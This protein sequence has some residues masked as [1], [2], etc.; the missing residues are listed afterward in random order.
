MDESSAYLSPANFEL[1]PEPAVRLDFL[2]NT[3]SI[4]PAEVDWTLVSRSNVLVHQHFRYDYP[5]PI[6]DLRHKLVLIP[7]PVFGGQKRTD[8][9]V[10]VSMPCEL[11]ASS[12]SFDNTVVE[13]KAPMV[14]SSIEFDAWVLI[15]RSGT[16]GYRRLPASW[17]DDPRLLSMTPRTQPDA[18]I[19]T[20]ALELGRT[21][22]RELELAD[23]INTWVHRAM[24]YELG[25]TSVR[26]I[27]AQALE[28]GKGVCQD[29][30]H[31]MLSI[32]RLLGLPA[33]YVSGHLLGE[34]GTHA[35]VEVVLPARDGSGDAEAWALDP[36]HGR[37]ARPTYISVAVGADY[38]DVAPTSGSYRAR[39]AGNLTSRRHVRLTEVAYRA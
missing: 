15:E 11:T 31:I 4:N 29:Y 22:K 16:A 37:R 39:H 21:G 8:Y 38:G 20:A 1:K 9:H 32:C 6:K 3:R 36:T 18:A 27:A 25:S 17:L 12:D 14:E 19:E 2:P 5:A 35:W 7:P 26:T 30:A 28:D 34:G 33:L 13:V 24:K 23:A 10:T